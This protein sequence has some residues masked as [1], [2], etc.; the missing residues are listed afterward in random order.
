MGYE[1]EE[2]QR[3]YINDL[4]EEITGLKGQIKGLRKKNRSLNK[5]LKE[6]EFKCDICGEI[7]SKGWMCSHLDHTN[8]CSKHCNHLG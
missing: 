1:V 4:E 3:E 5:R 7:K 8:M 2:S 6:Y